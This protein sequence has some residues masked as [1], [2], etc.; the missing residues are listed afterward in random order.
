[1]Q[2]GKKPKVKVVVPVSSSKPSVQPIGVKLRDKQRNAFTEAELAAFDANVDDDASFKE[3][4]L[5]AAAK[6]I[7]VTSSK[8]TRDTGTTTTSDERR[9]IAGERAIAKLT[10]T[11]R[12]RAKAAEELHAKLVKEKAEEAP[13]VWWVPPTE[14]DVPKRSEVVEIPKDV[15]KDNTPHPPPPSVSDTPVPLHSDVRYSESLPEVFCK[16]KPKLD[17]GIPTPQGSIVWQSVCSKLPDTFYASLMIRVQWRREQR[18]W[19][20]PAVWTTLVDASHPSAYIL[21]PTSNNAQ[22]RDQ[23]VA[24]L[25]SPRDRVAFVYIVI[26]FPELAGGRSHA[27]SLLIDKHTKEIEH[28]E[29]HG[30]FQGTGQL[31]NFLEISKMWSEE[32]SVA[33]STLGEKMVES[34]RGWILDEQTPLGQRL[35][36]EKYRYFEPLSYSPRIGMQHTETPKQRRGFCS[37]WSIYWL[38][39][40]SKSPGLDRR[41]LI[42]RLLEEPSALYDSVIAFRWNY[43]TEAFFEYWKKR[44]DAI[45]ATIAKAKQHQIPVR[46]MLSNVK[47]SVAFLDATFTKPVSDYPFFLDRLSDWTTVEMDIEGFE[48]PVSSDLLLVVI[49]NSMSYFATNDE[50]RWISTLFFEILGGNPHEI[51]WRRLDFKDMRNYTRFLDTQTALKETLKQKT[52]EMLYMVLLLK[53]LATVTHLRN[54]LYFILTD[55]SGIFAGDDLDAGGMQRL[56]QY[57]MRE[58]AKGKGDAGKVEEF[59][60]RTLHLI[61]VADKTPSKS[62]TNQDLVKQFKTLMSEWSVFVRL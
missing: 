5:E 58:Q 50:T 25:D 26:V 35:S 20:V 40:R 10:R 39:A 24:F 1:M 34:V 48:F 33:I 51:L 49:A 62:I 59:I 56:L 41:V 61:C 42:E 18:S 27:N 52:E 30:F 17:G 55:F 29:P 53:P 44:T 43:G 60:G 21:G 19:A 47:D 12:N 4:W 14:E 23:L 9:S 38:W 28:F 13:H 2:G 6:V 57:V 36:R 11:Y 32:D 54:V 22:L 16:G 45:S 8:Y 15:V 31:A 3:A 46:R 7:A 37:W